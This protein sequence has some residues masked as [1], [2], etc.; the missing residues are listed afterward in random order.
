[1]GR[2]EGKVENEIPCVRRGVEDAIGAPV[3]LPVEQRNSG[4]ALAGLRDPEA[5]PGDTLV[6]DQPPP[7]GVGECRVRE[8]DLARCEGTG[9]GGINPRPRAEEGDLDPI[10]PPSGPSSQ[11]VKYHHSVR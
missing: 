1:L 4:I 10:G 11:P 7:G 3:E 5:L 9:I 6:V 2:G 8:D